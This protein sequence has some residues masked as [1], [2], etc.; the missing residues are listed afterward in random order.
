MEKENHKRRKIRESFEF[1]NQNVLNILGD[2]TEV[3]NAIEY[4]FLLDYFNRYYNIIMKL[5]NRISTK[6][7]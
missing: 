3:K 2:L 4:V 5:H 6:T 7:I 1:G